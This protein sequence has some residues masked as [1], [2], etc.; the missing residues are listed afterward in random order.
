MA[1]RKNALFIL[2]RGLRKVHKGGKMN[3]TTE[4]PKVPGSYFWKASSSAK[5]SWGMFVHHGI[6]N[7]LVSDDI[8]G[9]HYA[10]FNLGGLWYG[11]FPFEPPKEK[12]KMY[13]PDIGS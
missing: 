2:D 11:P 3:W 12:T 8:D 10:L 5:I 7:V 1:Y 9:N 13:N 4:E 6:D